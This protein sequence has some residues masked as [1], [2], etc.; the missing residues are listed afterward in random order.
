MESTALSVFPVN[1]NKRVVSQFSAI[2]GLE[3]EDR[4]VIETIAKRFQEIHKKSIFSSKTL[5]SRVLLK[6]FKI[7]QVSLASLRKINISTHRIKKISI[8]LVSKNVAV[9]LKRGEPSKQPLTIKKRFP[10]LAIDTELLKQTITSFL[11]DNAK[12]VRE[13]DKRLIRAVLECILRWTWNSVAP[14]V[15]CKL[16]GDNYNFSIKGI[17]TI[18]LSQ[19]ESLCDLGDY[20]Q[21]L[22]VNLN[23]KM[24]HFLV[25]RTSSYIHD[26]QVKRRKI[27]A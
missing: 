27:N 24:V 6:F 22:N 21:E 5:P 2:S 16:V 15:N 17:Q 19:L 26:S 8:D 14:E 12:M 10:S 1:E 13:E 11:K 18:A 3:I 7:D 4:H 20:V 25:L 9:E 23:R